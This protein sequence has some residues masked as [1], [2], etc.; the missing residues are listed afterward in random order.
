[1]EVNNGNESE[2]MKKKIIQKWRIYN[3]EKSA[4]FFFSSVILSYPNIVVLW[5]ILL[6]S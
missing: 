1:M 6:P 3:N 2:S 5:T 4:L